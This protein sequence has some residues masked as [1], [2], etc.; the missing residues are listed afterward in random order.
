[1]VIDFAT[2]FYFHRESGGVLMGMADR[3]EGSSFNLSVDPQFL[4]KLLEIALPRYPALAEASINRSWA[5][6]Y[7][8]TPDAHPI[9][10]RV[11]N[12]KGLFL[13]NGFSGH[14]FQHGPVT[15]KLLAEEILHGSARTIDITPLRL[16]R[17]KGS[18]ISREI[19][20]V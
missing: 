17:F 19:N 14:G 15:G 9:L 10:G 20:V 13:A 12:P 3:D 5:G 8:V 16:D 18:S 11:E 1:M 4:E 6:L 7:A 2:T